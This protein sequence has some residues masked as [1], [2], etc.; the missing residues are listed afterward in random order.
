[1]DDARAHKRLTEVLDLIDRWG[2]LY[3]Q[4]WGYGNP[5]AQKRPELG[6]QVATQLDEV[7]KQTRLA[8]T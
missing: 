1:M 3:Y 6:P 2:Q 5:L 7:R 8:E 4:R